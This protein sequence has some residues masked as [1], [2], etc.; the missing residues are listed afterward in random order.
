MW[1][2]YFLLIF[3]VSSQAIKTQPHISLTNFDSKLKEITW[4]GEDNEVFLILTED[5]NVYKATN[6]GSIY[7]KLFKSTQSE[8]KKVLRSEA[9]AN[10]VF[11]IGTEEE[12]WFSTNCGDLTTISS[13]NFKI[14]QIQLHPTISDW[15]LALTPTSNS[16]TLQLSQDLGSHWKRIAENILQ[17]QWSYLNQPKVYALNT[18]GQ[19]MMTNDFFMTRKVIAEEIDKFIITNTH[20]IAIRK[21]ELLIANAY[22]SFNNL[23]L[24]KFSSGSHLHLL[25]TSENRV[26]VLVMKSTEGPFGDVYGSDSFGT[27]F[28][29]IK[30]NCIYDPITGAD[31]IKLQGLEATYM[32]NTFSDK[33]VVEYKR[34]KEEEEDT[35]PSKREI[36]T[37]LLQN[38]IRTSITYNRGKDWN[39]LTSPDNEYCFS[40]EECS[41]H[42]FIK[43]YTTSPLISQEN[44]PGLIIANGNVGR[45][46]FA[47]SNERRVYLSRNGGK[48]WIKVADK[49]YTFGISDNGAIILLAKL[50]TI[51]Y[52]LNAGINWTKELMSKEGVVLKVLTE[53]NAQSQHLLVQARFGEKDSIFGVDFSDLITRECNEELDF[54][55]WEVNSGCM[56]GRKV[57]YM[58]KKPEARCYSE[59]KSLKKVENCECTEDDYECEYGFARLN[60]SCVSV[61]NTTGF[62]CSSGKSYVIPSGYR[63]IMGDTCRGGISHSPTMI[64]CN[65]SISAS[66]NIWILALVG[67]FG[68]LGLILRYLFLR[69]LQSKFKEKFDKVK[70]NPIDLQDD[71]QALNI[72]NV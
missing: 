68:V 58:R 55:L 7:K 67:T 25:D 3:S 36:T 26:F 20:L 28:E 33:A 17:V 30:S 5:N 63:K 45:A 44:S 61:N 49:S 72:D 35:G 66:A 54:E 32:I 47:T 22:E 4:C 19:L 50:D 40:Y 6:K 56:L 11:F 69:I 15:I 38:N 13:N 71:E 14:D 24:N 42:L 41:L 37:L 29:L 51:K 60:N 23:Y 62:I 18:N 16:Y 8:I 34:F 12:L 57:S 21:N 43:K 9:N 39:Y 59:L 1:S 2:I 70:Y 10:M 64:K 27:Q 48:N 52:S 46:L 65:S 53:P 31:F